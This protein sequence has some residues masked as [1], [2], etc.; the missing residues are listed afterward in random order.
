M[1]RLSR[2]KESLNK[3]IKNRSSLFSE[4]RLPSAEIKEYLQSKIKDNDLLLPIMLLTIMNN[5]NKKNCK[6]IQGYYAA[7]SMLM[8]QILL[9]ILENENEFRRK[10]GDQTFYS[11][12]EYLLLSSNL[13]LYQN[14][15]TVKDNY[16]DS[17]SASIIMNVL[18]SYY[19]NI[20]YSKLLSLKKLELENKKPCSDVKNW[21]IRDNQSLSDHFDKLK[22]VNKKTFKEHLENKD[23]SLSELSFDIGWLIGCGNYKDIKKIR[24]LARAFCF[25]YRLANDFENMEEDIRNAA[26][27]G[28]DGFTKNIVVNFGLQNSHEIFMENKQKFIEEA[29][30]LDIFTTTIKE[31]LTYIENKVDSVIDDTSPDLKSNYSNLVS[32][33]TFK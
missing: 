21:Y 28:A 29:M 11:L 3:F 24:K 8:I 31:I 23:I 9:D 16:N 4:E 10:H 19:N 6:T 32:I 14:L 25:I 30:T 5:Q 7:S 22:T 20:S 17:L 27:D 2:Y 13:S 26:N 1:S 18:K 15:E 12:K 33:D